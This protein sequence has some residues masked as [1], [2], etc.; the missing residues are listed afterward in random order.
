MKRI[1][2][3]ERFSLNTLNSVSNWRGGMDINYRITMVK[4][5]DEE[6]YEGVTPMDSK[7]GNIAVNI[8]VNGCVQMEDKFGGYNNPK[9]KVEISKATKVK[10]NGWGGYYNNYDGLWGYEVHKKVRKQIR[11]D[12][13]TEITNYLKIFGIKSKAWNGI[14]INK[15]S[16]EK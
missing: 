2:K 3:A 11:Q 9:V 8:K 13:L 1:I 16:F 7:W 6:Y 14:Y 10:P 5:D 15:I 12:V 4:A